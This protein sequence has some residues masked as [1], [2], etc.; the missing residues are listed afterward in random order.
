MKFMVFLILI[1]VLYHISFSQRIDAIVAG[2]CDDCLIKRNNEKLFKKFDSKSGNLF[3]GDIIQVYK[4]VKMPPIQLNRGVKIEKII[5]KNDTV[6]FKIS[7]KDTNRPKNIKEKSEEVYF[8][9]SSARGAIPIMKGYPLFFNLNGSQ[10]SHFY[11]FDTKDTLVSVEVKSK[12][13]F[14]LDTKSINVLRAGKIYYWSF[15]D[16]DRTKFYIIQ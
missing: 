4:T 10:Y 8:N 15:D 7:K 9:S 1:M 16:D 12:E 13:F 6:F 14:E 3:I 11:I 2:N 5:G